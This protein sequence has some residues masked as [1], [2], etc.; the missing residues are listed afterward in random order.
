ML[1]RNY[2]E[3]IEANELLK[4]LVS[5]KEST[6][7]IKNYIGKIHNNRYKVLNKLDN[8]S[9]CQVYQVEDLNDEKIMSVNLLMNKILFLLFDLKSNLNLNFISIKKNSENKS[10][11]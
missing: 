6:Q 7:E 3:R 4:K 8:G 5:L 1:E 11:L 9:Y 10:R 2:L